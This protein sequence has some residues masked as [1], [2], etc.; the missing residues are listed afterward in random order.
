VG[1]FP[2]TLAPT[3]RR[4]TTTSP[5]V[6]LEPSLSPTTRPSS[7]RPTTASPSHRETASPT[8][9]PS[10][11]PSSTKT[12]SPTKSPIIPP[13][14]A[15]VKITTVK[16]IS[17]P[18]ASPMF[19]P[20][21]RPTTSRPTIDLVRLRSLIESQYPIGG[22]RF[23]IDNPGFYQTMAFTWLQQDQQAAPLDDDRRI[24]Q[25]YALAC[26]YYASNGVGN[27]I[28][29]GLFGPGNVPVWSNEA[30]WLSNATEC[31]WFGV[32][33]C[34]D[35][36][37]ILSFTMVANQMSGVL[38]SETGFLNKLETLILSE[39]FINNVGPIGHDW[40]AEL[41]QLT[42]LDYSENG[43]F[44]DGIPP[45]L[46]EMTRLVI[47]DCSQNYYFGEI[48]TFDFP[49]SLEVV[50]VADN[51]FAG[52]LAW[53][54]M[55]PSLTEVD[56]SHNAEIVGPLPD[57][58]SSG[59][60]YFRAGK[61]AIT[62]SI[63]NGIVAASNLEIFSAPDNKLSGT[64]EAFAA[65]S[66]LRILDV[67]DNSFDG[68]IPAVLGQLG[69]LETLRLDSN[70]LLGA[71]PQEICSLLDDKLDVLGADCMGENVIPVPC[72]CCTCC[73][74]LQCDFIH[75]GLPGTASLG[76]HVQASKSFSEIH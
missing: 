17:P 43:F 75:G 22:V 8:R 62:G 42:V 32:D 23:S 37:T 41:S 10:Y 56:V 31:T 65:L 25:R 5:T 26:I 61:C 3:T 29:D 67:H 11:S 55:L 69:S 53:M 45:A 20:T 6:F 48:Q 46:Y 72:D 4:P 74:T 51:D 58:F 47:Y 73:S 60:R 66:K 68:Q 54:T 1:A 27:D 19:P 35:D 34:A 64:L 24:I 2:T 7:K 40:L 9:G 36:D 12:L 30:G 63:P 16:P 59:L 28:T 49:R 76:S 13:S 71:M 18:S 21:S 52:S 70:E 57:T 14:P 44:F 50:R 39:N 15:P 33:L 38:P